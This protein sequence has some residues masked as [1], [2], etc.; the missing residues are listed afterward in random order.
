M[1][2]ARPHADTAESG[3]REPARAERC[4]SGVRLTGTAVSL[5][6]PDP[7]GS[8]DWFVD[9]LGFVVAM[10]A[11]GFVSLAHPDSGAN[12]VLL[13]PDLPTLAPAE[14]RGSRVAGVLLAFVVED[15][16]AEHTRL[17]ASG[18]DVVA[19]PET[20]PWGERFSQ[21]RDPSGL[22]VQL[23]TWVEE[24]PAEVVGAR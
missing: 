22:L 16:D 1:I 11:D 19:A 21:Y 2:R 3:D 4:S 24:P 8:A 13:D 10:R 7:A 23:V 12:L 15:V 6:V 5:V 17:V 14:L 9:H 18:V 20:E